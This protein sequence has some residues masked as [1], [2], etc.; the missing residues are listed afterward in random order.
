MQ[1]RYSAA[2]AASSII[3]PEP[4]ADAKKGKCAADRDA[5][6]MFRQLLHVLSFAFLFDTFDNKQ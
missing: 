3:T 5:G 2:A 4:S 1:F 6:N